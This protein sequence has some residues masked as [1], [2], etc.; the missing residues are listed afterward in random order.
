MDDETKNVLLSKTMWVNLLTVVL[1]VINRY[2]LVVDPAI[3]EPLVVVILP[4]L[5]MVLRA[6][7]KKP[8]T[9]GGA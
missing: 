6:V 3:I 8:V 7:T 9:L 4:V 2:D 1:I 5:N